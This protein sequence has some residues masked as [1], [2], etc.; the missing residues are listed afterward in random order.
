MEGESWKHPLTSSRGHG[1]V[2]PLGLMGKEVQG[3]LR[4]GG[5]GGTSKWGM[6]RL[7]IV[8]CP[9]F[10]IQTCSAVYQERLSMMSD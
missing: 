3:D 8:L 9:G 7:Y 4:A 5:R 2:L 6:G 1:A 10:M